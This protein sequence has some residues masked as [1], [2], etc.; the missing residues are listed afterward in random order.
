MASLNRGL[1]RIVSNYQIKDII[2]NY[3]I[4][5]KR[6][7]TDK[8][9]ITA[10]HL[11]H[12]HTGS[13]HIHL[14]CSDSNNVFM[15]TFKTS[16]QDSKG[17]AHILEHTTLCG[18]RKFPVR[19]PFFNMLKRSLQNYMNLGLGRIILVIHFPQQMKKIFVTY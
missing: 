14:D 13:Q 5:N 1:D 17:I 10:Y 7:L 15:I 16:P 6:T 2:S 18:S 8:N 12:I 3:Q 4:I 11:V 9:D 19:D